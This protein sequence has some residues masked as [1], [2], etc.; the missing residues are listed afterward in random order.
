M[1]IDNY[2]DKTKVRETAEMLNYIS[3][4]CE[5][6]ANSKCR[7]SELAATFLTEYDTALRIQKTTPDLR[8]WFNHTQAILDCCGGDTRTKQKFKQKF[9]I[10][11]NHDDAIWDEA[12]SEMFDDSPTWQ[13]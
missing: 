8:E 13:Y 10:V 12:L 6:L 2:F 9:Q 7:Y 4:T 5:K 11:K 1:P 3:E